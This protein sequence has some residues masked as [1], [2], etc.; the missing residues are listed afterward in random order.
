V[1][2]RF[3]NL[4][5]P[6]GKGWPEFGFV[7]YFAHLA[8][9]GEQIRIFGD[10]RQTRNVLYVEDAAE[11]MWLAARA[12][13]VRGETWFAAHDEHL[14]VADIAAAIVRI[15][16]RGSVAHVPWPDERRRIEVDAVRISSKRFRD[17][18]GWAPRC[19]FEQGMVRMKA[20]WE[21]AAA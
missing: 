12:G 19:S 20:V 8:R 15:I 17:A 13:G 7:N 9:N 21:G 1:A 3:A 10:G 6:Y 4:Y 16:G 14:S 2:L 5:G 18:T 11:A